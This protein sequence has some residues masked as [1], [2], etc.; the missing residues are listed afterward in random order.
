MD[1]PIHEFENQQN[2]ITAQIAAYKEGIIRKIEQLP[3]N[4]EV[5]KVTEKGS[6]F[7]VSCSNL[8]GNWTPEFHDFEYQKKQLVRLIQ[9]SEYQNIYRK[10][11]ETVSHGNFRE[12]LNNKLMFLHPIMIRNLKEALCLP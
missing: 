11:L 7:I 5:T 1:K 4:P 2:I 9:N 8:R 10:L 3:D 12:T 6:C